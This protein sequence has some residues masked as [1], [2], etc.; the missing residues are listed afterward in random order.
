VSQP[1]LLIL[2][3]SYNG[4]RYIAEQ[5]NS[6][7]RQSYTDW[8]LIVRDDG[9][10]DATVSIVRALAEQDPRISVLQDSKGN[11]GP[12]ASFGALLMHAKEIKPGYIALSD[13][14]D[15]WLP[16][17][18][19]RELDRLR[20]QEAA[21]GVAFPL[22]IHSDLAV[23]RE[24]LTL[25]HRSFLQYQGLRH[26]A[27]LPLP[28]LLI[29]NFVTGSTVV[30]NRALL[31]YAVPFPRV[32]MHDWWLALCAAAFGRLLYLPEPTVLYRQHADN[33]QGSQG[34]QAG[35]VRALRQPV[36]WWTDSSAML[37]RAVDQA[38]EL[39]LRLERLSSPRSSA[40]MMVSEF[41]SA[42]A[43][44]GPL[45]RVR[46]VYRHGIRPRSLWPYP[47]PFFTRVLLWGGDLQRETAGA[48][49][50]SESESQRGAP[51]R[52]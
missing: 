22:L 30:F 24:D 35:V 20:D 49:A 39:G 37:T 52:P 16:T 1:T 25:L 32:I 51:A 19:A 21:S 31:E 18:L 8:A 50:R 38:R 43:A 46:V 7:R 40:R 42:F 13:Q 48:P 45:D 11:L 5:I 2:L 47:V 27:Q 41:C 28:V 29:Q 10:S 17:K 36:A 26:Q 33:A 9:S 15:V 34:R 12:A 4:E 3:S 44:G 23:V 14:D 6:I